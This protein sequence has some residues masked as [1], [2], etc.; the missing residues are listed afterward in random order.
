MKRTTRCL[1]KPSLNKLKFEQKDFVR[2]TVVA[3][4]VVGVAT[5][6]MNR[7]LVTFRTSL[8]MKEI[9]KSRMKN[10]RNIPRVRSENAQV[11]SIGEK[12]KRGQTVNDTLQP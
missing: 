9:A 12:L 10:V 5:G 4:A 8:S 1:N 6:R 7:W 2:H 3:R 11:L